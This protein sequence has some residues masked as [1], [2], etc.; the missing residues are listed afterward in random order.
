MPP[1]SLVLLYKTYGRNSL[2]LQ[3]FNENLKVSQI[4]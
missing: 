4:S 3:G 1:L 2:N